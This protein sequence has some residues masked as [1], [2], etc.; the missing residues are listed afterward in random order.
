MVESS[1]DPFIELVSVSKGF[2]TASG[3]IDI[4]KKAG[5]AVEKKDTMAVVGASGIG[6]STLLHILGTLDP[7]D[8][9]KLMFKGED[10][11]SY[12]RETLARFRSLK[13]GFVFQFHYLLQGFS[14]VENVMMPG[15]INGNKKSIEKQ[16]VNMLD[17]VG[18]SSKVHE[19]VEDLSGGEQQRVALAR[20][21]V[22]GPELLLAD[23]PTGNLDRKN[24]QAVHELIS[25]LNKELGMTVVVV[26]HNTELA[27]MMDKAVTIQDGR[28]VQS[29]LI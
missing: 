11:F 2:K 17:R 22:M 28:I 12:D 14:T 27:K 10:L 21:L 1:R 9:G 6:K 15:L 5:L 20:A 3:K 4:L 29:D 23:E 7:P 26:T 18:L 8:S 24:S 25:E 16:A 19:R 13:I